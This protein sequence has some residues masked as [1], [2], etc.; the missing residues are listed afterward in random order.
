MKVLV[1]GG[2]GREHALCDAIARSPRVSEVVC[3]P[4]SGGIAQVA[5]CV[6]ANQKDVSDLLRV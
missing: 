5:R 3:A 2:G 6:P 4:G 1:I